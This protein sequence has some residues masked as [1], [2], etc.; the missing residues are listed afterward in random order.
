MKNDDIEI[1]DNI[2]LDNSKTKD[3]IEDNKRWLQMYKH[4]AFQ[5]CNDFARKCFINN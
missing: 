2:I 3:F 4:V 1:I 5:L